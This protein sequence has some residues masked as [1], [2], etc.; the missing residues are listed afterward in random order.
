MLDWMWSVGRRLALLMGVHPPHGPYA[1]LWSWKYLDLVKTARMVTSKRVKGLY[2]EFPRL[3]PAGSE[4]PQIVL[5]TTDGR[6]IDTGAFRGQKHFV[7]F[8]GAIT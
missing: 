3:F 1:G 2:R 5:E 8:T 7:L 6:T 4:F